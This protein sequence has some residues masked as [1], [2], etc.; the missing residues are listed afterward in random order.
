[1]SRP[2][3]AIVTCLAL[4]FYYI[5]VAHTALLRVRHQ[6]GEPTTTGH[7][8]FDIAFWLQQKTGH[9]PIMLLLGLWLYAYYF[10]S[11]WAGII[12]F[13]WILTRMFFAIRFINEPKSSPVGDWI[14]RGMIVWL[15]VGSL[16]GI[17]LSALN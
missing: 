5:V 2:E 6:I 3:T 15:V 14:S 12:G 11:L 8:Q 1:M 10:S 17:T 4:L 9:Q 7:P 13:L 16:V